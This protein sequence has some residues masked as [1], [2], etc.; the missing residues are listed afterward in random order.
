MA[1]ANTGGDFL[2][3]SDPLLFMVSHFAVWI[4]RRSP[5]NGRQSFEDLSK[6]FRNL[7]HKIR[8]LD[9]SMERSMKI[10]RELEQALVPYTML[11]NEMKPKKKKKQQL[12]ITLFS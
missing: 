1:M 8:E 11:Y 3:Y 9:P 2:H 5:A 6:D 12:P 4:I 7:K 10:A